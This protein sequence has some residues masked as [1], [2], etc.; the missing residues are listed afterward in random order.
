MKRSRFFQIIGYCLLYFQILYNIFQFHC[1]IINDY[2][3]KID[4]LIGFN[5][6]QSIN[7]VKRFGWVL[8]IG[9]KLLLS[10]YGIL[11]FTRGYSFIFVRKSL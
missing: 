4:N 5:L 6:K 9:S 11:K 7:I 1:F 3:C 2:D 8:L 10:F